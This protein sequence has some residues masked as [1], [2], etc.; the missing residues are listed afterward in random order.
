MA[1]LARNVASKLKPSGGKVFLKTATGVGKKVAIVMI[2]VAIAMSVQ[3]CKA[4]DYSAGQT[5]VYVV[6]DVLSPVGLPSPK[7]IKN[8]GGV[9]GP[10]PS[11]GQVLNELFGGF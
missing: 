7:S 9:E 8:A 6:L 3:D 2:P 11:P 5:T 4:Q 1:A 10:Y